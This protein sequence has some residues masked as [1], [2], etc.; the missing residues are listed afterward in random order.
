M[1]GQNYFLCR[2]FGILPC[3][4]Q[5]FLLVVMCRSGARVI[6]VGFGH[7]YCGLLASS[8]PGRDNLIGVTRLLLA[9]KDS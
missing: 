2:K 9:V 5:R 4:N 6:D 8:T 7:V 3:G 1:T